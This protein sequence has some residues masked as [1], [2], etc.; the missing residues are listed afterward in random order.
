MY[1]CIHICVTQHPSYMLHNFYDSLSIS[2]SC[3]FQSD[4]KVVGVPGLSM[5]LPIN[6]W[7]QSI[8]ICVHLMQYLV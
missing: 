5:Y 8:Q 3:K 2:T 1:R 4:E 7:Y 6:V